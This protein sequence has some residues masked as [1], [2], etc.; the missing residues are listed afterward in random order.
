[1]VWVPKKSTSGD[2]DAREAKKRLAHSMGER[3]DVSAN[4]IVIKSAPN[5]TEPKGTKFVGSVIFVHGNEEILVNDRLSFIGDRKLN[6]QLYPVRE[7]RRVV[8]NSELC[9]KSERLA[10]QNA[11]CIGGKADHGGHTWCCCFSCYRNQRQGA[12]KKC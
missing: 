8:R 4:T 5:A 2:K 7:D 9:E 11:R 1:M 6:K 12:Y 10:K 3:K